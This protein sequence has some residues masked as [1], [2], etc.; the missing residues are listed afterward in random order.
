L[1]PLLQEEAKGLMLVDSATTTAEATALAL[2]KAHLLK[3]D[4]TQPDY[5]FYVTD[6]PLR[7][8]TI[9]ERFLGRSMDQIEMVNLF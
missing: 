6:I 8:R 9:G 4:T 1:K 5:R 7:F 3:T 2:S